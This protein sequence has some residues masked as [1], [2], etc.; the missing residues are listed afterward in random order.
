MTRRNKDR[1]Y[2]DLPSNH[3]INLGKVAILKRIE[4]ESKSEGG[5]NT[6]NKSAFDNSVKDIKNK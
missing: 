2:G 1:Y 5:K 3:L 6:I 4:E